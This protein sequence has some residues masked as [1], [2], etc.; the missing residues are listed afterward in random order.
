LGTDLLAAVSGLRRRIEAFERSGDP[1]PLHVDEATAAAAAIVAASR[2]GQDGVVDALAVAGD[3]YWRRHLT[4]FDPGNHNLNAAGVLFGPMLA[5]DRRRVPEALWA[6]ADLSAALAEFS[7]LRM[8]PATMCRYLLSG[9]EDPDTLRFVVDC[10]PMTL[11]MTP[12]G[13]VRDVL[14][15]WLAVARQRNGDATA[16]RDLDPDLCRRLG[17]AADLPGF[18]GTSWVLSQLGE[19]AKARYRQTQDLI[20]IDHAVAL[21]LR[22]VGLSDGDDSFR[23]GAECNLGTAYLLRM[24]QRLNRRA[25]PDA[26]DLVGALEHCRA[27]LSIGRPGGSGFLIH[28]S[29]YASAVGLFADFTGD[30]APLADAD[31]PL[32]AGLAHEAKP[33]DAAAAWYHRAEIASRRYRLGA[34][35]VHRRDALDWYARAQ[36]VAPADDP[37]QSAADTARTALLEAAV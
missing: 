24:T 36:A 2:D 4:A 11:V 18:P 35:A 1:G 28:A 9:T 30:P 15:A 34:G 20:D 32:R 25:G 31:D 5:I 3:L 29:S 8:A 26:Q 6:R 12:P 14:A 27:A 23:A 7:L 22:A 19:L 37:V 16:A 10:L 17:A 13:A 21:G 33:A